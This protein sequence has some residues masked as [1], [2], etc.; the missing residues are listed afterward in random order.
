MSQ[1]KQAIDA[2]AINRKARHDYQIEQTF[3]AGLC[4]QGWEVKS[5]RAGRVQLQES[6]VILKNAEAVLL[7]S[8]IS[9]LVSASTHVKADPT[10]NR[11][12]LLTHRELKHL[13]GSVQRKGYTIVPLKLYWK[14]NLVKLEIALAKGKKLYDKRETLKQR[15]FAR[16]KSRQFKVKS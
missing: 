13:I 9:P 1:K 2:I 7:G 6:Y 10:R 8:H 15:D 14:K 11:K 5:I 16:E 3:E 4:L 12:L